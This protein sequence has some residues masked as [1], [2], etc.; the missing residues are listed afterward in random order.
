M[1]KRFTIPQTKKISFH[2]ALKI[3]KQTIAKNM[4]SFDL[5]RNDFITVIIPSSYQTI[6][7]INTRG[8]LTPTL[9]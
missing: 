7:T 1:L 2:T 6:H 8:R 9:D 3:H 5:R 4:L